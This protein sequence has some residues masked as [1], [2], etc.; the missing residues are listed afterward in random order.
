MKLQLLQQYLM[1]KLTFPFSTAKLSI[2]KL[3]K[4][5]C[6]I[7]KFVR[8][9]LGLPPSACNA[10]IHSATN[11]L[12]LAI[13]PLSDEFRRLQSTNCLKTIADR[14]PSV[15]ALAALAY[16]CELEDIIAQCPEAYIATRCKISFDTRGFVS[17]VDWV[18]LCEAA[19]LQHPVRFRNKSGAWTITHTLM[20]DMGLEWRGRIDSTPKTGIKRK[21][22]YKKIGEFQRECWF[23]RW[24][25]LELQGEG[26]RRISSHDLGG[27]LSESAV[28]LRRPWL[29][30][31]RQYSWAIKAHTNLLPVRWNLHQWGLAENKTCQ[32]CK[33]AT[34]TT[35][36]ALNACDQRLRKGLYNKRHNDILDILYEASWEKATG[37]PKSSV[38]KDSTLSPELTV[39]ALRPDLTTYD[40]AEKICRI[41]DVK[42]PYPGRQLQRTHT[43][44]FGKYGRFIHPARR[45]HWEMTVNTYVVSSTGIVYGAT[46]KSLDKLGFNKRESK[47]I[48]EQTVIAGIK[49]CY[50]S[51]SPTLITT[52]A[53]HT[54]TQTG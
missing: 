6:K 29:L 46:A 7:R 36:H 34:E 10:M 31:S 50:K 16:K 45:K 4:L 11:K 25:Q 41:V 28:W 33:S 38:T 23:K 21:D 27:A 47:K 13:R 30:T 48:L 3:E 39:S 26:A 1:P 32:W 40:Y 17:P 53:N 18:E 44:N 20:C 49:G 12:G 54:E 35:L 19:K 22:I 14:E 8:V 24:K 9:S 5:D 42:C 15:R 51:I 52:T 2:A 43:R 37:K